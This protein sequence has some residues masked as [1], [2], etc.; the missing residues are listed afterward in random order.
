M[1]D[2]GVAMVENLVEMS[3]RIYVRYVEKRK[4]DVKG[5]RYRI[6]GNME[7]KYF[8]LI[9]GQHVVEGMTT[10][11]GLINYNLLLFI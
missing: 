1:E 10:T 6:Q 2:V 9:Y 5:M 11:H 3:M 7:E 4:C 8:L